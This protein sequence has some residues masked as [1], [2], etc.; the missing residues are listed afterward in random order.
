MTGSLSGDVTPFGLK[1]RLERELRPFNR[2]EVRRLP[3]QRTGVYAL[4]LPIEYEGRHECLYVGMSETCVR[5]RLIQHLQNETNPRLLRQLRLFR[6]PCNVL[7]STSPRVDRRPSI[8]KPQSSRLG[9]HLPTGISCGK[10]QGWHCTSFYLPTRH[11]PFAEARKCNLNQAQAC[12]SLPAIRIAPDASA[13]TVRRPPG[14]ADQPI[15]WL[16]PESVPQAKMV[17]ELE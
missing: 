13:V 8:W 6:D 9:N 4:W 12:R 1:Y 2:V 16:T 15:L 14:Y 3:R 5:Q 7:D 11:P 10:R 17:T